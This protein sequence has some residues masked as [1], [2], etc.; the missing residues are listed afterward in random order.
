MFACPISAFDAMTTNSVG[1]CGCPQLACRNGE[2]CSERSWVRHGRIPW[3]YSDHSATDINEEKGV[4]HPGTES[5]HD[6]PDTL[7][8]GDHTPVSSSDSESD[9]ASAGTDPNGSTAEMD[10]FGELY[11][12]TSTTLLDAIDLIIALQ[13]KH[14]LTKESL[15]DMFDIVAVLLP[16]GNNMCT[17]DEA[18]DFILK[19]NV[20]TVEKVDACVNDHCLFEN[21]PLRHDSNRQRQLADATECPTCGEGRYDADGKPRKIIRF[22]PLPAQV[23]KMFESTVSHLPPCGTGPASELHNSPGWNKCVHDDTTG[24]ARESRNQ[25]FSLCADGINPWKGK[26]AYSMWPMILRK[27]NMPGSERNKY[28]NLMLWA[29]VPGDFSESC[30]E[31]RSQRT[32]RAPK[33]LDAYLHRLVDE[34]MDLYAPEGVPCEDFSEPVGSRRRMFDVRVKLLMIIADYPGTYSYSLP[35]YLPIYTCIDPYC[36]LSLSLSLYIYIYLSLSL[37]TYT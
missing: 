28:G 29:L 24:F 34:L 8:D 2:V 26:G 1:Q 23:A 14:K 19:Y 16:E 12:G 36:S 30:G 35:T 18:R 21:A 37:S 4:V 6:S 33:T 5:S 13:T 25:V 27:E 11:E 7:S 9:T 17:Y 22:F 15:K 31:R 20:T 3:T 32:T 10:M